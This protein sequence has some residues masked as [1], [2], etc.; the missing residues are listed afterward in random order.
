MLQAA[1]AMHIL[2]DPSQAPLVTGWEG[3]EKV[4]DSG[5]YAATRGTPMPPWADYISDAANYTW[6]AAPDTIGNEA[7]T[8]AAWEQIRGTVPNLAPVWHWG[9]R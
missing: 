4:K 8:V 6:L 7:A 9:R 1:G 3:V 5:A 2:V